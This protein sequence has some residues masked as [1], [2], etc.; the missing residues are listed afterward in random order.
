MLAGAGAPGASAAAPA[1]G[2]IP[3]S[4]CA[5]GGG[6]MSVLQPQ[7]LLSHGL[8][9]DPNQTDRTSPKTLVTPL[10]YL[11]FVLVSN[12]LLRCSDETIQIPNFSLFTQLQM[13]KN[14]DISIYVH[15]AVGIILRDH[16]ARIWS[17]VM[18]RAGEAAFVFRKLF[19]SMSYL[20]T[21]QNYLVL[22]PFTW[23]RAINHG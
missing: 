5:A 17:S 6:W 22:A 21:Q 12:G 4:L 16:P 18:S 1:A 23:D 14:D 9:S 2:S 19:Q 8:K 15:K 20:W 10:L 13:G 11:G 7:L 3:L